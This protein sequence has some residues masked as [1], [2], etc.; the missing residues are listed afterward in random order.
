M[1][2]TFSGYSEVDA[3]KQGQVAVDQLAEQGWKPVA[4]TVTKEVRRLARDLIHLT[5]SF[6]RA[7][8]RPA[9]AM[10]G[11][12]ASR[13]PEFVP[14]AK[15]PFASINCPACSAPLDPVPKRKTSCAHCATVI[16]VRSGPDGMRHLLD[17]PGMLAMQ[18]AW[19]AQ[20]M[21]RYETRD[22]RLVGQR[23]GTPRRVHFEVVGESHYQD[24][25]A[26]AVG[27]RGDEP[28]DH[29]CIVSL[30]PEPTNPYDKRAV[31]VVLDGQTVGYLS[32]TSASAYAPIATLLEGSRDYVRC[33]GR[34]VGGW[35][36]GLGDVGSFGIV[37]DLPTVDDL[38]AHV[39]AGKWD[40]T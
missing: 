4:E 13:S 30:I 20:A 34:I 31:R 2:R 37:V 26:N 3:R 21:D 10:E 15:R 8:R 25:L 12:A 40:L 23:P 19:D 35:S 14:A 1:E 9:V 29:A 27:G 22:S 18:T 11:S 17:E 33:R 38:R 7:P 32:R 36:R 6:E 5:V 24:V 39:E 28:V 16:F